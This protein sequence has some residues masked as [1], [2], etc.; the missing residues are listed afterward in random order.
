MA[1]TQS[2]PRLVRFGAFEADV[3]TSELRK[4]GV[5]LR[6]SGQPFQVLAILLERPGDLVTREELQKRLWPDTFVDVDHN[7]NTAINKIREALGD[8]AES[9]RFVETVPRRGYRFIGELKVEELVAVAVEPVPQPNLQPQSHR[10]WF[11]LAVGIAVVAVIVMSVVIVYRWR[12]QANLVEKEAPVTRPF[13]ALPG[14]EIEPAFSPDGSRIA[15]AWNGDPDSGGK[16]F[17][18][19]VKALG[20]ETILRLTQHPSEW[21]KPT[22]SPDG[23]QIAF[24]RM[25]GADT[26]IYI[27]PAMGGPERKLRSTRVAGHLSWSPDGKWIT[28]AES[29]R[30]NKRS[31]SLLSTETWEVKRLTNPPLCQS[32]F[33]SE[34]SHTGEELAFLCMQTGTQYGIYTVPLQG[35]SP[36]LISSSPEDADTDGNFWSITSSFEDADLNGV[37]WSSDDKALICWGPIWRARLHE[38]SISDGKEKHLDFAQDVQWPAFSV[39]GDRLAF[40]TNSNRVSLWRRDLLQ[41]DSPAVNLI[42]TTRWEVDA[43]Y[44]PDGKHIAFSSNRSGVQGVWV[45]REDGSDLVEISSPSVQS[46]SPQWSPDGKRIAFDAKPKDRWEVYVADISEGIPRKLVTNMSS[47]KR[48]SW[49]RDGKWIY[50]LS[51]EGGRSGPYR[52]SAGGGDAIAL[53]SNIHEGEKVLESFDERKAYFA[54]PA[55]WNSQLREVSLDA[56]PGVETDA[57]QGAVFKDYSTWTLVPGGIYFVPATAPRSMRYFDFAT[58]QIRTV[59]ELDKDF[60]GGLSISPDGRWILYAQVDEVD[61]DIMLVEH[62]H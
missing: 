13:T 10:L 19:Y 32:A 27:V 51:N 30:E 24:H 56:Q 48:P 14:M 29:E 39:K 9:P 3:Q 4:D 36:K 23:T 33:Y 34:F 43:A 11:R 44:S 49:S 1:D 7:L 15:F 45:S 58:K 60:D 16:G 12:R 20:S 52:C 28:F 35:G 55:G 18:L 59:F 50:F 47:A 57:V 54:T 25:A 37:F 31:I 5:K 8:S 38:V 21:L 6:F 53:S 41:P 61:S 2:R 26:G 40:S 46:G 17:D 42:P 62:F 22:W